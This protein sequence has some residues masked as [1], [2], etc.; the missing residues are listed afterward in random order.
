M[1]LN[2]SLKRKHITY[3]VPLKS[4]EGM[5]EE[6]IIE[7]TTGFEQAKAARG[8]SDS[9]EF[10]FATET[11]TAQTEQLSSV[12]GEESKRFVIR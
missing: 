10:G 12:E 3:L 4:E 1:S 9:S 8:V 6:G 7:E 2:I 11:K 5:H